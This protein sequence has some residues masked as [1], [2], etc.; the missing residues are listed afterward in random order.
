MSHLQGG[1]CRNEKGLSFHWMRPTLEETNKPAAK[2]KGYGR[3]NPHQ[4]LAEETNRITKNL[5]KKNTQKRNWSLLSKEGQRS[6]ALDHS[7]DGGSRGATRSCAKKR[8]RVSVLSEI[9]S[10][11]SMI[12]GRVRYPSTDSTRKATGLSLCVST[13]P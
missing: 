4:D 6:H 8:G 7:N 13:T 11:I 12:T 10:E 5:I 9:R 3:A 2:V 1:G